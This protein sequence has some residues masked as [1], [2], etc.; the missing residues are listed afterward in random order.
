LRIA[1]PAVDL[2]P[3]RDRPDPVVL[4][5]VTLAPRH[6]VAVEVSRVRER[7]GRPLAPVA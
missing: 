3:I 7:R 6:G 5:G 1:I 4:R 2:R